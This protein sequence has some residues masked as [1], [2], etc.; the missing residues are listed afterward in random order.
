ML[1]LIA[2]AVLT[3]CGYGLVKRDVSRN[4]TIAIPLFGNKTFRPNLESCVTERLVDLFARTGGG[5]VVSPA[6]ADLEL[7]GDILD[8]SESVSGY[9]ASDKV[10]V[11]RV[12]MTVEASLRERKSG[13]VLWKGVLRAGQD[14][15]TSSDLALKLNAEDAARRELC[16][17]LAEDIERES[18]NSF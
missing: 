15:P 18:G 12:V 14:Y 1:I 10:A 7:T 6:N 11:Y 4:Q 5:R 16:R 13:N 8:Y 3:G 9:N 2:F 17:K